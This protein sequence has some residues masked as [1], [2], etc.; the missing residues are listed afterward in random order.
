MQASSSRAPRSRRLVHLR[1]AAASRQDVK[2]VDEAPPLL[3]HVSMEATRTAG[4]RYKR[5]GTQ[6]HAAQEQQACQEPLLSQGGASS[7]GRALYVSP[8]CGASLNGISRTASTPEEKLSVCGANFTYA[9][10]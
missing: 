6:A 5:I 1:A 7:G 2:H 8:Y 4:L 3:T 9:T 10:T